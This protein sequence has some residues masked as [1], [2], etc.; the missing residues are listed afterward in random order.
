VTEGLKPFWRYYGG[1]WRAAPR[2]PA[3]RH[4]TIVEPF[5]GSAGYALRYHAL[6]VVLVERY[7]VVAEMWRWLVGASASEVRA[8]PEVDHVAALPDW[9]PAGARHLVGFSMSSAVASPR[10]TL[11]VGKRRLREQGRSMEGWNAALRE[12]VARQV[13][14]IR[15]WKVI[16]GD[17]T[18]SPDVEATWFVDPPYSNAAGSHYV[19]SAVD[20]PGLGAWCRARRGQVIA[21]ENAGATW[22]PFRPFA[23][24]KAGPNS[25]GS[26]EVV[27]INDDAAPEA[28]KQGA[29]FSES[30]PA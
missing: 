16:E 22:L 8:I 14:A 6:D 7:A 27:W 3:P 29:L 17:Y 19:H 18:E 5:A 20:Y 12:R 4:R 28:W 9:V 15:H 25:A 30:L 23:V 1:K 26:H 21:C 13:G 24:L 11:S 2:Y 10:S